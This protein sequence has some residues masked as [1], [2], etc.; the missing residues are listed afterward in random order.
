MKRIALAAAVAVIAVIAIRAGAQVS[1]SATPYVFV[2]VDEVYTEG[3]KLYVTGILQ[4]DATAT[5]QGLNFYNSGSAGAD[6][7]DILAACERKALLA[8]A[9]PGQYLFKLTPG[10][11][12][13][14][15]PR[16]TLT[17]VNP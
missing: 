5:T 10:M 13:Y 1:P 12:S 2:T 15:Y 16:C 17:R 8:M 9:K 14:Y 4:G 11:Y 3:H 6:G 7:A